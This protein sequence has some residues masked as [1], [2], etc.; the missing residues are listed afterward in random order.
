MEEVDLIIEADSEEDKENVRMSIIEQGS[1]EGNQGENDEEEEDLDTSWIENEEFRNSYVREPMKDLVVFFVYI[2]KCFSI[3]KIIKENIEIDDCSLSKEKLLHLIQTK[4]HRPDGSIGKKYKLL[5][6]MEFHVPLEPDE[7]EGFVREDCVG[8]FF[9]PLPIF[10]TINVDP[11]IFIFHGLN[12]LFFFFKEIENPV[13]SI[14]KTGENVV[15]GRV[16][17]KVRLDTGEYLEKKRKSMK[18]MMRSVRKTRKV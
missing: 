7:L 2:D 8:R 16:T 4:R 13:K 10:Q 12:S 17:K 11:S 9:K 5:D 14:L 6:L 1:P 15:S 3:E 18:R